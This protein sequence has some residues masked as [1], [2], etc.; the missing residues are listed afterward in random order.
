MPHD[1]ALAGVDTVERS[2]R[3][4]V[5][6]VLATHRP[7]SRRNGVVAACG[8]IA[9][10][11]T[12]L[13][14]C[15][16]RLETRPTVPRQPETGPILEISIDETI[17]PIAPPEPPALPATVRPPAPRTSTPSRTR[18]FRAEQAESGR[19]LTQE[20]RA[21]EPLD[22]TGDLFVAGTARQYAGGATSPT[23]S[24]ASPVQGRGAPGVPASTS[25]SRLPDQSRSVGLLSESWSCPWPKDAELL[26]INE[27]T[28][29]I[30]VV[31]RSDGT[32]ETVALVSDPGHGF[33]DAAAICA[34]R[35]RFL[36]A[37]ASN[38][39]TVRATSPPITVR[40]TR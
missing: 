10:G 38:G 9:F 16:L 24:N 34:K 2:R 23:G 12:L 39:E 29:V 8:G 26:A 15:A 18:A 1:A 31:A 28:A 32:V 33:G 27:Q 21:D 17:Q 7:P 4:I 25:R 35:M 6:I 40:F 11:A 36:P 14:L 20:Q 13:G 5:D 19:V 37:R 30:R 3:R 22:L